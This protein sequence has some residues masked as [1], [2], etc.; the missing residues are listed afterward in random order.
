M[1]LETHS[2]GLYNED[3]TKTHCCDGDHKKVSMMSLMA[4]AVCGCC[5]VISL[6]TARHHYCCLP[7]CLF[8]HHSSQWVL[9]Q[10]SPFTNSQWHAGSYTLL[11]EGP[12]PWPNPSSILCLLLS[13]VF[14][15]Y[16][17]QHLSVSSI[18][19]IIL[20]IIHFQ[21]N[22]FHLSHWWKSPKLFLK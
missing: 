9:Q 12:S 5:V 3:K 19:D 21:V 17:L 1:Q 18:L 15:Q 14:T 4:P 22:L 7:P 16:R 13:V 6:A 11:A 8:C 10:P 20:F 2:S